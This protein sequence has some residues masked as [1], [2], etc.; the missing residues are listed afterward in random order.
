MEWT[1]TQ[2]CSVQWYGTYARVYVCAQ[3]GWQ[4]T[5]MTFM[6]SAGVP[7]LL[8]R[9]SVVCT[10]NRRYLLL[11]YN[12]NKVLIS[13][14]HVYLWSGSLKKSI[15]DLKPRSWEL[16]ERATKAAQRRTNE[17]RTQWQ[18]KKDTTQFSPTARSKPPW[19]IA[20]VTAFSL[21]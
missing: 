5:P 4:G 17:N 12:C 10:K 3:A 21:N 9:R 11:R 2:I 19:N 13:Y 1:K 7:L 14:N 18:K 6:E 20:E 15:G 16:D 8:A